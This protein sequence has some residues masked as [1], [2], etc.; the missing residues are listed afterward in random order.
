MPLEMDGSDDQHATGMGSLPFESTWTLSN[1]SRTR[2]ILQPTGIKITVMQVVCVRHEYGCTHQYWLLRGEDGAIIHMT[3]V[4]WLKRD[5]VV[6][7]R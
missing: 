2:S 7:S 5:A 3:T 4:S 1:F 6:K